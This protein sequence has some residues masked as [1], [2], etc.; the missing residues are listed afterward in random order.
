MNVA[1]LE[2]CKTGQYKLLKDLPDYPAGTMVVLYTHE[3]KSVRVRNGG[4]G[5][6]FSKFM[7]QH[8]NNKK[9]FRYM[10]DEK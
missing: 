2:N 3:H 9:W 8:L 6:E 1:S 10:G 4:K 5:I 7:Y